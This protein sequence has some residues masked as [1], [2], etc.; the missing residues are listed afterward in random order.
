MIAG[1][2]ADSDAVSDAP[3]VAVANCRYDAD[4]L[5]PEELLERYHALHGWA[6]A[7]AGAGAGA[8]TVVQRFRRDAVVR[9]GSVEYRFVGDGGPDAVRPWFGGARIA[10]VVAGLRADV[11]H[12]HGFVFP[13]VVSALRLRAPRATAIVVQDHGGVRLES[14]GWRRAGRR[15]L[16]GFG[17][18]AADG[19]MFTAREQ[20]EPW[21]AAGIIRARQAVYEVP[22]ASTDLGG[23][24]A[25]A[26]AGGALPGTPA[27]LWVGR[28]DP[29]KDPLTVLEGFAR[30]AASL[31]G[32]A[33]T[34]VYGDDVMLPAVR[35]WIAEHP[36]IG[37]R[38][39]LRGRLDRQALPA[40]YAAA[41]LFVIGSHREVAC[42]SLIEALSF[43]ATP[44][45]TDIPPFRALTGNGHIGAL[46]PPGD[47]GA[48]ARAIGA[49][50]GGD[51]QARRAQVRAHFDGALSWRAVGA[52]AL[53]AY[54][55]AIAA[56]RARFNVPWP[57]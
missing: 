19:F 21:R 35:D 16:F 25:P 5:D 51:R 46:C 33:L 24:S 7:L 8:V 42:F 4:I 52:R 3:T 36:E 20:A 18:G 2:R 9:R 55:A 39:H 12:V 53:A 43:G 40:L 29:N 57:A 48:F 14:G 49:M 45:I 41:D 15:L 26:A 37:A 6:D 30:A 38:I 17:L 56:R 27:L 23:G 54:R 32:A 31:P 10:R 50:G 11:V 28:L 34:M 44:V 22:E 13:V 47:A 1:R